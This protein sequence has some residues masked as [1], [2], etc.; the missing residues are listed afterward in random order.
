MSGAWSHDA[1]GELVASAA[2]SIARAQPV[3]VQLDVRRHRSGG[4]DDR[5]GVVGVSGGDVTDRHFFLTGLDRRRGDG[6]VVL[7][8]GS[9][10]VG[11]LIS[12]ETTFSDLAR[13]EESR[14]DA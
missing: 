2:S 3:S 7:T 10:A 6:P 4:D 1:A 11:P 14:A 12:F 5:V 13:R 9:L 8:A